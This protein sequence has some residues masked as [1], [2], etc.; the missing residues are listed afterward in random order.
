MPL[1]IPNVPPYPGVP[2]LPGG[3]IAAILPVLALVD[4]IG[5]GVFSGPQWGIFA[6]S[7]APVLVANSVF[8]VEYARDYRISDYPQEQGAFESYNKVQVPYQA[9]ITFLVGGSVAA[10]AAFLEAAGSAVAALDLFTIVT[11]EFSYPNANLTHYSY[12]REARHG[13]TLIMV[14]VWCEEVRI[15]GTAQL[16]PPAAAASSQAPTASGTLSD[17]QSPNGAATQQGGT[18]QAQPQGGGSASSSGQPP[19]SFTMTPSQPS[20]WDQATPAQQQAIQNYAAKTGAT[21]AVVMAPD[22]NGQVQATFYH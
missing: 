17:T 12:R 8:G 14:D 18:V 10:R 22:A 3:G 6:Q 5:L 1:P 13:V 9:K 4:A 16:S 21:Q 2:P 11:P 15:T 19:L 7:G 20:A